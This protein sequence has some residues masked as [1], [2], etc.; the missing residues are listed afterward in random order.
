MSNINNFNFNKLDVRLTNDEYWDFF[1]ANDESFG[2][3]T[4]GDMGDGSC[5]VVH[6]DFNNIQT[7][8]YSALTA[9]SIVSLVS[10]SEAVNTGYTF[11]TIGLTGIDNGLIT[12]DHQVIHLIKFF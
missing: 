5:F 12:F 6:Y 10:W 9:T 1:I 4:G 7:Y 2:G 11:D 8:E 3:G